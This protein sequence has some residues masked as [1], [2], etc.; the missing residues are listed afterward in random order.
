MAVFSR[1]HARSHGSAV[2][3]ART[4]MTSRRLGDGLNTM[5]RFSVAMW[6]V[7]ESYPGDHTTATFVLQC[8][9]AYSRRRQAPI[10]GVD[11]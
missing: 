1:P 2:D 9:D 5:R 10:D 6:P 4:A 7:A 11:A 8:L 3:D